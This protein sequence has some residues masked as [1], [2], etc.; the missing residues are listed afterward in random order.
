[1]YKA[2]IPFCELMGVEAKL[3]NSLLRAALKKET[4]TLQRFHKLSKKTSISITKLSRA[5]TS[6]LANLASHDIF[7]AE[8]LG[9]VKS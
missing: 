1:M 6:L 4:K 7:F 8:L 5:L 9:D 2:A 3:N